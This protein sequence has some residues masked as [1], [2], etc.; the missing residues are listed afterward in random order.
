[1]DY[2]QGN[3][4]AS[5]NGDASRLAVGSIR[6]IVLTQSPATF[7]FQKEAG[8][9]YVWWKSE[10]SA[11]LLGPD[12]V[13]GSRVDADRVPEGIK[14][15]LDGQDYFDP[16][17]HT[18][19]ENQPAADADAS[20]STSS[21]SS[22]AAASKPPP[23]GSSDAESGPQEEL[24]QFLAK[25]IS[26]YF[27]DI[28]ADLKG[29]RNQ[30]SLKSR[31]APGG[32]GPA[33]TAALAGFK[34]KLKTRIISANLDENDQLNTI[35]E[36]IDPGKGAFSQSRWRIYDLVFDSTYADLLKFLKFAWVK[37]SSP[38]EN[39]K[40]VANQIGLLSDD[41]SEYFPETAASDAPPAAVAGAPAASPSPAAS[42]APVAPD[43]DSKELSGQNAQQVNT[44]QGTTEGGTKPAFEMQNIYVS[45]GG[46]PALRQPQVILQKRVPLSND[47]FELR[48]RDPANDYILVP[49][50]VKS[51][52]TEA[53]H[54]TQAV[55][56][57]S[58][59]DTA[60]PHVA[61]RQIEWGYK[62]HFREYGPGGVSEIILVS[63]EPS[64][65][66]DF[67]NNVRV[68]SV[69]EALR[70]GRPGGGR[71]AVEQAVADYIGSD[72]NPAGTSIYLSSGL[73]RV[74]NSFKYAQYRT[75]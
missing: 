12:S 49:I 28:P 19:P 55:L 47:I 59:A 11:V 37:T 15:I 43:Q 22:D 72:N 75:G 23:S 1:M 61:L 67:P 51:P 31:I 34:E 45:K 38:S 42:P 16:A 68:V 71:D 36:D 20:K 8:K 32:W 5:Y 35:I 63:Y 2:F 73:N 52:L 33:S 66:Q 24:Q 74:M 69:A 3:L 27:N 53:S 62:G 41:F 70:I 44:R 40:S 26:L 18:V 57:S 14:Q 30:D 9:N 7:V 13:M 46:T 17:T 6:K 56:G 65:V 50:K 4:P 60:V 39:K 64:D 21:G 10:S 54:W 48:V 58:G 29:G 25:H